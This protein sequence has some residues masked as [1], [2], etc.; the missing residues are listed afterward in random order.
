MTCSVSNGPLA[1]PAKSTCGILAT[2]HLHDVRHVFHGQPSGLLPDFDFQFE[3][4]AE[5]PRH[6]V[7]NQI[8]QGDDVM[9]CGPFMGDDEIGVLL[10]DFGGAHLGPF[11]SC[12]LD[13]CRG[14]RPTQVLENAASRQIGHRLA[15]LLDDPLFLQSLG[16]LFRVVFIQGELGFEDDQFIEVTLPIGKDQ[17]VA[18]PLEI[19][20]ARVMRVARHVHCPISVP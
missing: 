17:L 12:L 11:E 10:A 5:P 9:A 18:L 7:P 14:A 15:R 13:Q 16:Q 20:P 8:D 4:D 3:F 19:S 2:S 1:R 6:F